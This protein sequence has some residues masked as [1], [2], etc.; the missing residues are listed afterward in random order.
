ML[1]S[2]DEPVTAVVSWHSLSQNMLYLDK[3]TTEVWNPFT[4]CCDAKQMQLAEQMQLAKQMQLRKCNCEN[5]TAQ[6]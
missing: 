4:L 5:A 2:L 3:Q 6:M 1:Q